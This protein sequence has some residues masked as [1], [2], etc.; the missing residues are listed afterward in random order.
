MHAPPVL[1][2]SLSLWISGC[3]DH[4][5]TNVIPN[6]L[7]AREIAVY[8]DWLQDFY[9]QSEYPR[10]MQYVETETWPYPQQTLCDEK[11]LKDGV[12]PAYLRALRGLGTA[13]YTIPS[14]NMGFA[15]T[16]DPWGFTVDGKSPEERFIRHIFS[17]VV[18]SQDGKQAF[19][20]VSYIKGPGFGQG[21]LDQDLLATRDGQFWHFRTVGCV[22]IID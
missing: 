15:R 2:L 22:G 7:T 21:G 10:K 19:L 13:R 8:Q 9:N 4:P 6:A 12:Q 18:F 20:S 5:A 16:F 1:L 14:F 11:L 17:R 3:R